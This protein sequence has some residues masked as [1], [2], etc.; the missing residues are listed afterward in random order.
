MIF[1]FSLWFLFKCRISRWVYW[2]HDDHFH[3]I[4]VWPL[5]NSTTRANF[6]GNRR[7][8][9][10]P[11]TMWTLKWGVPSLAYNRIHSAR[12]ISVPREL[13]MSPRSIMLAGFQPNHSER[14][15]ATSRLAAASLPQMKR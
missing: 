14:R 11:R 10:S 9:Y 2:H 12:N 15:F 3:P 8:D 13:V 7:S 5:R 6:F 4:V 1:P